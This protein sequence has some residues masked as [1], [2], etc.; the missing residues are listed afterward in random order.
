MRPNGLL[1]TFLF[2]TAVILNSLPAI[3]ANS[4]KTFPAQKLIQQVKTFGDYVELLQ[5]LGL[6]DRI[7]ADQLIEDIRSKNLSPSS[8]IK[9]PTFEKNMISFD[10]LNIKKIVDGYEIKSKY[11]NSTIFK[12]FSHESARDIYF[13]F[14]RTVTPKSNTQSLNYFWI[15][16]AFADENE[17]GEVV[18]AGLTIALTHGAKTVLSAVESVTSTLTLTAALIIE[19]TYN[20]I[21]KWLYEGEIQC[22]DGRYTIKNFVERNVGFSEIY[23][24]TQSCTSL[25]ERKLSYTY[26]PICRFGVAAEEFF[27][28]S[29]QYDGQDIF[30]KPEYLKTIGIDSSPCSAE[31]IDQISKDLKARYRE[32]I[33]STLVLDQP[34]P[35]KNS[36]TQGV[37]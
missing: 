15:S 29:M 1:V 35:T 9:R 32:L 10:K 20:P 6:V 37:K 8:N 24:N 22:H 5:I 16:K 28:T 3:S 21:K 34:A 36:P 25:L 27:K 26:V 14:T 11:S 12:T 17:W 33:S 4:S 18:S 19:H 31:K 30:L 2:A 13:R 23:K 7:Q